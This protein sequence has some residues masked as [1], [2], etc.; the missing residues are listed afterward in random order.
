MVGGHGSLRPRNSGPT[1]L[2]IL[3]GG[4]IRRLREA[5]GISREAA[6][7]VIRGS[8]A[9]MSRIETGRTGFKQ[10]D[11]VDLLSLYGVTDD[12]EREA[13]LQLARQANE[14]GWWQPY[15]DSMPGWLELYVGLEQA[16]AVIRC[17]EPQFVPGLLQTEGY[18]KSVIGLGPGD[19][20]EQVG[21]RVALR[22][23]RQQLMEGT[24]V[25][26]FW[27]VLDEAVL[28]RNMGDPAVMRE[29]LDH[30]LEAVRRPRVT[31]QVLPFDRSGQ[32]ATGGG[33]FSLLRFA[34]PELPDVVYL[35][36]LTSAMYLDRR[37]DVE[38]Y[39]EVIDRLGATAL[40][41]RQSIAMIT[42]VRDA[43]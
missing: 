29:Q 27:V 2:R 11:I 42:E 5:A 38:S 28:H 4:Q 6:A 39:L 31:V 36:Q 9:K 13:V 24:D 10:R 43:L 23:R 14:P 35:E 37:E 41:P 15:S 40:T 26:D 34:E 25:P 16:A 12:A 33:P 3:V 21:Q 19:S 32:V 7:E 30:I 18:A 22:M 17:Y 20:S 8:E 1:V